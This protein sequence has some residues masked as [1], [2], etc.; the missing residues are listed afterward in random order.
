MG[1]GG[2][3][4]GARRRRRRRPRARAAAG[5]F[6]APLQLERMPPSFSLLTAALHSRRAR[7]CGA[8]P[9]EPA[10][11]L[12]CG[13]LLCAGPKCKR[14]ASRGSGPR[15]R[16]TRRRAAAARASSS[17]STRASSSS[18][19]AAAPRAHG[20]IYLDAHG[21]EDRGLRRGKPLYLNAARIA[22]LAALWRAHGV[23]LEVARARVGVGLIPLE[24]FRCDCDLRR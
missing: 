7:C 3:A 16:C 21:E 9:L 6:G 4:G 5:A 17:S 1:D 18:S 22:E 15:A 13:T 20:S 24:Y 19:T 8:P 14:A 10:L 23:P 11:C 12:L 2:A